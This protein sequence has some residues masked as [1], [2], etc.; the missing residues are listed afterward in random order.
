MPRQF[1]EYDVSAAQNDALV[2][3]GQSL[4]GG[5]VWNRPQLPTIELLTFDADA[6]TAVSIYLAP[7]AGAPASERIVLIAA[8]TQHA[9]RGCLPWWVDPATLVAWDLRITKPA[10]AA[11]LRLQWTAQIGC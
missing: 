7:N 9:L 11:F 1:N 8:S 3:T 4:F 5:S 2:V 10:G 6:T